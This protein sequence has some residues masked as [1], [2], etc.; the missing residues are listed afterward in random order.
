MTYFL[1]Y[2]GKSKQTITNAREWSA[3]FYWF[4]WAQID[5]YTAFVSPIGVYDNLP[6]FIMNMKPI[7]V[8]CSLKMG[9]VGWNSNFINVLKRF[10]RPSKW[11]SYIENIMASSMMIFYLSLLWTFSNTLSMNCCHMT[12]DTLIPMPCLRYKYVG[13]PYKGVI[14]LYFCA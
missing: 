8:N 4:W 12:V 13:K 7:Y 11:C 9:F 5:N 3:I 6:T 10:A 2:L 14:S 1:R